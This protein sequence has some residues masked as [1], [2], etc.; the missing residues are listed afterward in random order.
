MLFVAYFFRS[1]FFGP[2]GGGSQF[3][4]NV[5]ENLKFYN[6]L[7]QNNTYSHNTQIKIKLP[8]LLHSFNHLKNKFYMKIYYLKII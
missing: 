4:R 1:L 2:E 8:H 5:Y 6:K 7:F 3:F